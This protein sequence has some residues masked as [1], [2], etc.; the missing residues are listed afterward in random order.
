M[1]RHSLR[2]Y[3]L[4]AVDFIA[5]FLRHAGPGEKRLLAA[6]TASGKSLILASAWER[7]GP[8]T[9]VITPRVEI[10]HGILNQMGHDVAELTTREVVGRAERLGIYTPVRLRNLLAAGRIA[11]PRR[12]LI[13]E[14]HHAVAP[15]YREVDL[16]LNHVPAVGLTATPFRGTPRGTAELLGSWGD[17]HWVLTEQ[18]AVRRGVVAVPRCRVVGLVDDDLIDTRSGDIEV[19]PAGDA[20]RGRLD[21]LIEVCRPMV[22]DGRWDRAT[23]L[24]FPTVDSATDAA[25]RF[26]AAG[27][28]TALVTGGTPPEERQEAFRRVV[29]RRAALVHV[30]VVTE[31]VDLPELRRGID[32]RPTLSPVLWLQTLG[33]V[34][35]P[36]PTDE[37]PPEYLCTN[38]NLARHAYLLEGVLPIDTVAEAQAAFATPGRR[39]G[40]RV[41]GLEGLGRFRAAE[42][43]L[44]GGLTGIMFAFSSLVGNQAVE[45]AVLLHPARM[46]P[47]VATRRNGKKPDGT[48][49]YGRWEALPGLPVVT[50]GFASLAATEPTDKQK[51]WW[52]RDAARRGLAPDAPVN[53]RNFAALPVL[54]DL[55]T[56]L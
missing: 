27:L 18:Q 52:R 13:D 56:R 16:L 51:A 5:D 34:R 55:R 29:D 54:T 41:V 17:V 3:Q 11:Y 46:A 7:S 6:P 36:V 31:G 40:I 26:D 45:Y 25:G 12:L 19:T 53:R 9:A 48:R 44:A 37:S 2:D 1:M 23:M 15:S 10:V 49:A 38:R 24:T 28:P 35:R 33:R 30:N 21:D 42:L 14:V 50:E 39:A 4:V 47:I 8:G 20:I 43:P 32:C 22:A